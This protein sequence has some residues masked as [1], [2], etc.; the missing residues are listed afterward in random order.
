MQ[1]NIRHYFKNYQFYPFAYKPT[2]QPAYFL[3]SLKK[4]HIKRIIKNFWRRYKV[5]QL[6]PLAKPMIIRKL[7]RY[8]ILHF[9]LPIN[10]SS[11]PHYSTPV[12]HRRNLSIGTT[13]IANNAIASNPPSNINTMNRTMDERTT[14][15]LLADDLAVSMKRLPFLENFVYLF[16]LIF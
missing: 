4:Q 11:E 7:K 13:S 6:T 10:N 15:S 14:A 3:I 1:H 12:R 5:Y 8:P 9:Q 16:W 2:Y